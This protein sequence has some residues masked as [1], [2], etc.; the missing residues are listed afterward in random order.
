MIFSIFQKKDRPKIGAKS[1]RKSWKKVARAKEIPN[2]AP[3]F[4]QP[5]SNQQLFL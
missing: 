3:A 1:F 2:F 4:K 5:I